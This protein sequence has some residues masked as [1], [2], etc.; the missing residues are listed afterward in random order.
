MNSISTIPSMFTNEYGVVAILDLKGYSVL[1]TELQSSLGEGN[2]ADAI[3]RSI[4]P[5]FCK[6]IEICEKFSGSVVKFAGDSMTV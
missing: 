1:A 5:T 2:G 4:N 6:M 3:Q